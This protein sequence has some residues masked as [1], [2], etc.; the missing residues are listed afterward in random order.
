MTLFK[1]TTLLLL[2][3]TILNSCEKKSSEPDLEEEEIENNIVCETTNLALT[4]ADNIVTTI[5]NKPVLWQGT[6]TDTSVTINFTKE[7]STDK[8]TETTT[9]VFK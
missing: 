7:I 6:Y 4:E 8:E 5:N 9:F 3:I 1:N 2:L